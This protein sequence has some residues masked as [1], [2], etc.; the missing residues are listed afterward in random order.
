MTYYYIKD[1]DT[2]GPKSLDEL[3]ALW[4][5]GEIAGDTPVCGLGGQTWEPFS[6]LLPSPQITTSAPP[7]PN[8]P[9][10]TASSPPSTPPSP[11]AKPPLVVTAGVASSPGMVH[12]TSKTK[13]SILLSSGE[14]LGPFS[15]A[16]V[17]AE[18]CSRQR[19]NA[20]A[21]CA[22][23]WFLGM[24]GFWE[25]IRAFPQ[26]STHVADTTVEEDNKALIHAQNNPPSDAECY[27]WRSNQQEG[28][29]TPQQIKAMWDAGSITANTLYYY[30]KLPDWCP[31][32]GFCQ[33]STSGISSPSGPPALSEGKRDFGVFLTVIGIVMTTY[34]GAFYDT[35]VW[36]SG[37]P[38]PGGG[39]VSGRSVVNL[40]KQQNRLIGVI[41]GIA[42]AASG[43]A[44][45][46]L[47]GKKPDPFTPRASTT[48]HAP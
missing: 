39:Y 44:M 1:G 47:S 12:A 42:I 15:E 25:P 29:F 16:E 41:V 27:L 13:Y 5:S 17:I 34:F 36:V 48:S 9:H 11:R 14:L 26:F 40:D 22:R 8:L 3:S 38:T 30:S 46:L 2:H 43:I 31:V 37:G 4:Q 6:A 20:R 7:S 19:V 21:R 10:A 45:I 24:T 33:S 28:P 18:C 32:K 35:S 23:F